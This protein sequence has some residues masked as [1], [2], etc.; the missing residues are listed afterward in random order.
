MDD[1]PA[2]ITLGQDHQAARDPTAR[3]RE[4]WDLD[5]PDRGW[6]ERPLEAVGSRPKDLL[7]E[8]STRTCLSC[9]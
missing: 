7:P 3:M 4:V 2:A 6:M 5:L 9:R 8:P 1:E